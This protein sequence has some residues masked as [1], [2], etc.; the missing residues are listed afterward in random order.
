MS[1]SR[2]KKLPTGFGRLQAGILAI[3]LLVFILVATCWADTFTN[4]QTGEVLHGF[5]T[6]LIKDNK[7]VVRTQEKGLIELNLV[8]WSV[9]PDKIGRNNKVIVLTLEGPIMYEIETAAFERAIEQAVH[10][11]PLFILLQIDTPGGRCDYAQRICSA[12]SNT[13][14]CPVIGYVKGGQ[15]GGAV[16]AGVA[17]AL[18][19]DKIY[20]ASDTIIGAAATVTISSTGQPQA[21]ADIYG[22]DVAEKFNS[23]W[24]AYLASLAEKNHRPGLLARAMVDKDTEVIEVIESYSRSFIDPAN[25]QPDQQVVRIW[26]KKD[27]LLTLTAREAV[28]CG[29]ADELAD[30]QQQVLRDLD[31]GSAKVRFDDAIEEAGRELKRANGQLNRIIKSIDLKIK[32]ARE[33]MPAPKALGILRAARSEFATLVKLAK[34][35]P[36]LQLNVKALEEELNSIE[37]NYQKIRV[38]SDGRQNSRD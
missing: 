35:Y 3:L 29:I 1:L 6:L 9:V 28:E 5:A 21:L 18:A 24:R 16:S 17:V 10:E 25:R 13:A 15:F 7:A 19:C 27:S 11:G 33:P 30:S 12:I 26:N 14:N 32:Q 38:G 31:A 20:M 2:G 36:D 23:A 8:E 22:K 34:K 37:A 4:R